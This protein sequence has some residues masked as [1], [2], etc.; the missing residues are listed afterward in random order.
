VL[1]IAN[2][3]NGFLV[4][5]QEGNIKADVVLSGIPLNNLVELVRGNHPAKQKI[6]LRDSKQLFSAFQAGI[7]FEPETSRDCL[8]YQIQV[9][10]VPGL[11]DCRSFFLSLNHPDDLS[12]CEP[13]K[14]VASVSLHIP[15]PSETR[16]DKQQILG[17]ILEKLHQRGLISREKVL[18][19]HASGPTEWLSW[20]G[21]H[22]G[23]V[24]G[25]PQ[26]LRVR[27]WQM[28][29][30]CLAKGLFICGD[31]VY[32]GQGIPGVVLGGMIAAQRIKDY[33]R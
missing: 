28:Q 14:A 12:R 18:Y 23:F 3:Q 2:D 30:A 27:P 10:N 22:A 25:Y 32:P 6:A 26:T 13:G 11:P 20:T 1:E 8:H 19:T 29:S 31:S 4:K 21:R 7:V 5:T 24:G 16:I 9:E 17:F 33:L 15:N